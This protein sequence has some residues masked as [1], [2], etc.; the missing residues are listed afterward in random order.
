MMAELSATNSPDIHSVCML[1]S[2]GLRIQAKSERC[3]SLTTSATICRQ[4]ETG[5]Q[6]DSEEALLPHIDLKQQLQG[7]GAAPIQAG[8]LT[9]QQQACPA[10]GSGLRGHADKLRA[11]P[12]QRAPQG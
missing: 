2:I 5:I 6:A 4:H 9:Y 11:W 3:A 1:S 8:D 12:V 10:A 7:L